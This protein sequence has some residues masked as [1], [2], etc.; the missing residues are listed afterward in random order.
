MYLNV[1]CIKL[2][3]SNLQEA[4]DCE[5]EGHLSQMPLPLLILK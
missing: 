2:A 4:S 3:P 5:H 1:L